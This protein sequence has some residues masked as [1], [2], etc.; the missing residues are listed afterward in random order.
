MYRQLTS[1]Q[2]L[3]IFVLFQKKTSRKEIALLVGCSLS[4]LSRELKRNS[5]DQGNYLHD[6][7]HQKALERR[8]RT[9]SNRAE[10]PAIVWEA[11]DLLKEEDWSL[12]QISA[13]MKSYGKHISHELIYR[14]IRAELT[15]GTRIPLS[16]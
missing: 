12:Q 8:K 7:A 2:R 6:K 16:P 15:G 5:T 9:T 13:D 4:T 10:D 11:L 3:Q 1:E 14:H